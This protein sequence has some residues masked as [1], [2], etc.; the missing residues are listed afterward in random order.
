MLAVRLET[1]D[2]SMR[3]RIEIANRRSREPART[4]GYEANSRACVADSTPTPV[5]NRILL[6][7]RL[8]V[9]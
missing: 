7:K 4:V 8:K 3:R 9:P 5:V 2:G 1:G 6:E